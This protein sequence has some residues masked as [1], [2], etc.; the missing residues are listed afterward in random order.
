MKRFWRALKDERKLIYFAAFLFIVFAIIGGVFAKPLTS[1]LEK[2]G[3]LDQLKNL[4]SSMGSNPAWETVFFKIFTNNLLA[5]LRLIGFG[6]LF[7][8]IPLFGMITNGLIVGYVL[9]L[10]S[11]STGTNPLVLFVTT[12]LPHGVFE[13]PAIFIAA[14]LGLRIGYATF[15]GLL[16]FIIPSW[17]GRFREQWESIG[18][19]LPVLLLG[20]T[21]FLIVAAM[22]EATLI[23]TI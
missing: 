16:S 3:M 22:I 9:A 5:S 10:A 8:V 13:L 2:S 6:V 18:R 7:G 15:G 12:L 1:V 4:S 20:I 14:A 21:I 11:Q 19:N 23:V 17:K